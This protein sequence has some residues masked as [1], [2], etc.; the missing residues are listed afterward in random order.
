MHAYALW[1]PSQEAVKQQLNCY[2]RPN[3]SHCM[4]NT[5]AQVLGAAAQCLKV[6]CHCCMLRPGWQMTSWLGGL[7]SVG[8]LYSGAP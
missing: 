1:K 8:K 6:C 5:R 2:I 7:M 3:L 4:G